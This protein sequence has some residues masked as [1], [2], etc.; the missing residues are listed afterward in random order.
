MAINLTR[1][2]LIF[3]FLILTNCGFKVL[4]KTKIYDYSIQEIMLS[5]DKRIGFL[6]KNNF[7]VNS[8]KNSDKSLFIELNTNK[9]KNIKEKN[10]KSEIT[11]YE[12]SLE[13]NAKF[14]LN[15]SKENVVEIKVKV[16]GDY[17]VGK[18]YSSTLTNEKKLID[19]LIE[20][21]TQ[22]ILDEINFKIDDI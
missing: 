13:A 16:I 5:G 2:I 9:I 11:K 19:N 14:Y 20:K 17:V 4:D 21:L 3:L 10:I 22:E 7:L 15:P 6:L 18:N 1:V 8:S 12:I